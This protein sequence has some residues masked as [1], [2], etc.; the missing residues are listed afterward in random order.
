[1]SM[2]DFLLQNELRQLIQGFQITQAIYVVTKLGIA[3]LLK[4]GPRR[5]EELVYVNEQS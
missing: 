4:D 3:D 1:M 5:S 2:N